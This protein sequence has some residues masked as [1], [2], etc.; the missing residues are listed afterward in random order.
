MM[1]RVFE[2]SRSGF[3]AF[4]KRSPSK[5]AN[6]DVEIKAV[7][8][9][10]FE[11]NRKVY[12][13]VRLSKVIQSLGYPIGRTR[14]KRLMDE[15][16]IWPLTR[17]IFTRTTD[18]SHKKKSFPDLVDRNF[19]SDAPN[20]VWTSDITYIWTL[21]GFVYLAVILDIY[22]RYVVGWSLRKD[23]DEALVLS[24]FSMAVQRRNVPKGFIFHSDKGGQYFSKILKAQLN[25]LEVQQSMGSTGD[26]FDNAVTE[27][28]NA[29]IK[30]E[31]IYLEPI[32]DFKDA[33][34]KIFSYIETF[35]NSNRLH[36]YL[37][38]KSPSDFEQS[39]V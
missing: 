34:S 36:S 18:S 20:Q 33:Y 8:K 23:M 27:S 29:T 25:L 15:C 13:C 5:R 1:C 19:S 21:E 6:E 39:K 24:S 32:N 9:P 37:D 7:L 16:K 38:Y 28:F 2:V 35:Y 22:S 4:I 10:A 14:T 31:C 11:K 26:C 17:K 12:G 30:K 3:Y